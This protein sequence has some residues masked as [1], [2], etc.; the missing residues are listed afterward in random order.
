MLNLVNSRPSFSSASGTQSIDLAVLKNPPFESSASILQ[1][2]NWQQ[3]KM[4]MSQTRV[5]ENLNS[6]NNNSFNSNISFHNTTLVSNVCNVNNFGSIADRAEILAWLSPL[7]P[8]IRHRDLRAH[9]V[10]HVGDWLLGTGEY[11]NWHDGVY[12]GEPNNSTLFCYGYPGV[13]K[14]Y[15]R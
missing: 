3:K 7:E 4:K 11:R 15:I 5:G 8:R 6:F 14:T 12:S 1:P 10:E 13:G 9:R 2:S